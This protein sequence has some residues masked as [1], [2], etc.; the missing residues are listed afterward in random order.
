[1]LGAAISAMRRLRAGAEAVVGVGVAE[2]EVIGRVE[3]DGEAVVLAD[4]EGGLEVV[5]VGGEEG[6][7]EDFGG[8]VLGVGGEVTEEL[9][10]SG[11]VG[12]GDEGGG[13]P[14]VEHGAGLV[15]GCGGGAGFGEVF[16]EDLAVVKAGVV[17]GGE[18][19]G[20]GGVLEGQALLDGCG[21]G[22][23]SGLGGR[24]EFGVDPRWRQY[25][26]RAAAIK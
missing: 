5:A 7:A 15:G 4:A 10:E 13:S 21:V 19:G 11:G 3:G 6:G 12:V 26:T 25:G 16:E 17:G 1:M 20:G 2:G 14:V 24:G 23:E 18:E 9:L 22:G 8:E